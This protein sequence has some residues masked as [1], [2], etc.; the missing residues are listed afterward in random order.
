MTKT[1]HTFE[2]DSPGMIHV[3]LSTGYACNGSYTVESNH[4]DTLNLTTIMKGEIKQ[5]P[6]SDVDIPIDFNG[7]PTRVIVASSKLIPRDGRKN[8][9]LRVFV[10]KDGKQ[11]GVVDNDKEVDGVEIFVNTIVL[12]LA[13]KK[14]ESNGPTT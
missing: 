5:K 11:V 12:K 13:E 8:V 7:T 4:L 9:G 14:G 6:F 3:K 10:S 1:T 2:L